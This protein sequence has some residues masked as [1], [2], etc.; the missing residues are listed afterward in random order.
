MS[1]A[2]PTQSEIRAVISYDPLTGI[3]S[4][5]R[6]NGRRAIYDFSKHV[7]RPTVFIGPTTHDG[8]LRATRA[9]W[10]YMNSEP[11][12][13]GFNIAPKDLNHTN[14]KFENLECMPWTDIREMDNI[15]K[16]NTTGYRGVYCY[17]GSRRHHSVIAKDGVKHSSPIFDTLEQA[18]KWR[19]MMEERL[20]TRGI[21]E[22][23][24]E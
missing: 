14:L 22:R 20:Y 4:R 12:P 7:T 9:A 21:R 5:L 17:R 8:R 15:R 19:Q 10:I 2:E 18:V 3:F 6:P 23:Q 24:T 1:L 11:I 13:D 16:D